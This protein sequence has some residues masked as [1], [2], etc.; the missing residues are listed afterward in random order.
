MNIFYL[1]TDPK[2]AAEKQINKHVIKM[3]LESAQMLCTT[4]REFGDENEALYKRTHTNHPSTV[5][6][7]QSSQHYD[8]VYQ[9]M[10]ALGEE[11]TNRYGKTHL[12]ITKMK[13]LLKK[14]PQGLKDNGYEHPPQC[15]PEEYQCEDAV[16]AYNA[17]YEYKKSIIK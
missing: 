12:T 10:L 15:M 13:E 2:I 16:T 8:W 7:R 1:D 17:Y 14:P 5:W 3:I 4:H 6:I 11:Y 9:H